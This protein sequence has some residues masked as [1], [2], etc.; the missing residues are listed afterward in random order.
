MPLP[1]IL[2]LELEKKAAAQGGSLD[3]SDTRFSILREE[4]NRRF[5]DP[6]K[7]QEFL[8]TSLSIIGGAPA[9][10]AKL[11]RAG[12]ETSVAILRPVGG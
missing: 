12:L 4:A 6:G 3:C 10:L 1:S 11:S 7:A 9:D 2:E 5:G 8:R